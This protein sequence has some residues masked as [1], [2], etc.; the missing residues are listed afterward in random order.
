MANT[1]SEIIITRFNKDEI[2][3]LINSDQNKFNEALAVAFDNNEPKAWRAVWLISK[4]IS[5]NDARIK[6]HIKEIISSI[7][8][9]G[10]GH[11]R[12]FLKILEQMEIDDDF[13]GELYDHCVSIWMDIGKSPSVRITAFRIIVKMIK[14]YH[15]LYNE[16]EPLTQKHFTDT[17]SA[18]IKNSFRKLNDQIKKMPPQ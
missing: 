4:S 6:P 9:K 8:N 18:G 5:K 2:I 15:E 7:P 12:E 10:D 17:L 1:L 11:Q 13:E 14:K 16:I 3:P